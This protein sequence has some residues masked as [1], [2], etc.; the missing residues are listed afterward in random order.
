MN[1]NLLGNP[2]KP[3]VEVKS[4][5]PVILVEED[6]ERLA[7][8][9]VQNHAQQVILH[10]ENLAANFFDL[11]SGLAPAVMQQFVSCMTPLAIVGDFTDLRGSVWEAFIAECNDGQN[12]FF[13]GSVSE[14]LDKFRTLKK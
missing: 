10:R 5:G 3:I 12:I 9:L 13:L 2:K 14:A 7:E 1:I 4:A 6:I 11:Q 8:V